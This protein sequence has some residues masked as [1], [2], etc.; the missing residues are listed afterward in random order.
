MVLH[1]APSVKAGHDTLWKVGTY[2]YY[3]IL[4]A[5]FLA[6]CKLKLIYTKGGTISYP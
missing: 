2:K 3:T 1:H 6:W 4:I 5:L